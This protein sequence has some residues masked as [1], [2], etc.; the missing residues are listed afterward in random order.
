[1]SFF[2]ISLFNTRLY[3]HLV[4]FHINTQEIFLSYFL[5]L[6]I[7]YLNTQAEHYVTI[8]YSIVSNCEENIFIQQKSDNFVLFL[9]EF[10][11]EY[12]IAKLVHCAFACN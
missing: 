4:S 6:L 2:L 7:R 9:I 1:M 3:S 12:K 8:K 10:Y 11:T 5:Y